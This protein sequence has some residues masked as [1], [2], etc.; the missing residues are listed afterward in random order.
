[1]VRI[2]FG[3]CS[4]FLCLLLSALFVTGCTSSKTDPDD[5]KTVGNNTLNIP[6]MVRHFEKNKITIDS[7]HLVRPDVMQADDAIAIKVAGKEI[8]I[9]K[10]NVNIRK[11][12]EKLAKI[13]DENF[14]YLVGF[15]KNVVINGAFVMVGCDDNPKKETLEKVFMSFK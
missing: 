4:L 2:T 14:V 11:Q 6:N 8:G 9:Y 7:V 15:K 3:R 1:M 10:F 13:I 5:M 12:R